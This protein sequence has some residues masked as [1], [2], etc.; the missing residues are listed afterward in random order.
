MIKFKNRLLALLLAVAMVFTVIPAVSVFAD[1]PVDLIHD[2]NGIVKP[3]VYVT[4]FG[5]EY[6]SS[7]PL[8]KVID[9]TTDGDWVPNPNITKTAPAWVQVNFPAAHIITEVSVVGVNSKWERTAFSVRASNDVDFTE[10]VLIGEIAE[11]Y[12]YDAGEVLTFPFSDGNSYKYVRI[13]PTK[14]NSLGVREIDI[15]GYEATLDAP[16][17][18]L[19]TERTDVVAST[20]AEAY[21]DSFTPLHALDGNN[22]TA[23]V[24][25]LTPYPI[26]DIDLR[27]EVKI[28]QIRWLPRNNSGAAAGIRKNF[29]VY[30][31][32][33]GAFGGEEKLVYRRFDNTAPMD[34]ENYTIVADGAPYRYVRFKSTNSTNISFDVSEIKIYG[35]EISS[36]QVTNLASTATVTASSGA[37][38]TATNDGYISNSWKSTAGSTTA[39]IT[40]NLGSTPSATTSIMLFP[41]YEKVN[42]V[43]NTEIRKNFNIYGSVDGSFL[44]KELIASVGD[45]AIKRGHYKVFDIEPKVYKAIKIEKTGTSTPADMSGLGF[46]EVKI[47]S[48]SSKTDVYVED[49]TPANNTNTDVVK[50]DDV[51]TNY[52]EIEFNKAPDIETITPDTVKISNNGTPVDWKTGVDDAVIVE[53]KIAKI[54][55][56]ALAVNKA[57]NPYYSNYQNHNDSNNYSFTLFHRYLL[58]MQDI[59]QGKHLVL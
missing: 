18:V 26:F 21:S 42:S 34:A 57:Y 5:G 54:S 27:R 35:T 44:D 22:S 49:Y 10:S 38:P 20:S 8:S 39:D 4:N 15:K 13:A 59:L 31:S 1:S 37:N 58:F 43:E 32:A 47:L 56:K 17:D 36:S 30:V 23:S 40:Y 14:T 24:S 41:I 29:E 55:M 48:D 25:I 6:S 28:S 16:S 45:E 9:N 50:A 11:N 3:G 53:G 51:T 52:I 12:S 33:T 2:T 7:Y 19:L 46:R